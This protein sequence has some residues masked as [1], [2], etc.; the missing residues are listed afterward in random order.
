MGKQ[1]HHNDIR[2]SIK[3]YKPTDARERKIHQHMKDNFEKSFRSNAK[4]KALS[5]EKGLSANKWVKADKKMNP[6]KWK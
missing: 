6:D 1:I 3:N 2:A 4:S 5:K